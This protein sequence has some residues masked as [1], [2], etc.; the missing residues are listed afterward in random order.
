MKRAINFSQFVDTFRDIGRENQFTYSGKKA[1]FDWIEEYETDTGEEKELDVIALCCEFTEYDDI[2]QAGDDYGITGSIEE[3][4]E[5]LRENTT[6]IELDKNEG[7]I[8]QQY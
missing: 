6:V 8:I 4:M 7:I 2:S 3:I 5:E 1:L